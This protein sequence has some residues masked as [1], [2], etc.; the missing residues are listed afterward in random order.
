MLTRVWINVFQGNGWWKLWSCH[1]CRCKPSGG[2]HLC[3]IRGNILSTE[4][5]MASVS[6]WK[7]TL[8]KYHNIRNLVTF[9]DRLMNATNIQLRA[10]P[11]CSSDVITSKIFNLY[12]MI[13]N[14]RMRIFHAWQVQH[15]SLSKPLLFNSKCLTVDQIYIYMHNLFLLYQE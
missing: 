5:W 4:A 9:H 6:R 2:G 15:S 13:I 1:T 11:D 8:D 12:N 3:Q 10:L 14:D 7:L